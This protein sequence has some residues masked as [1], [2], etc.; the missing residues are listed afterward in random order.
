MSLHEQLYQWTA[1]QGLDAEA[2]RRLRALSGV[3]DP[4]EGL[5]PHLQRGAATLAAGLVGLGAMLWVAANWAELGRVPRFALLQG[6]LAASLLGAAFRPAWRGALGLLAV[7]ALGGLL[8]FFGQT[9]QT[10]ADA[11]QLFALWAGLALP[12]AWGARSELVWA[13]WTVVA[14]TAISLWMHT[15]GGGGWQVSTANLPVHALGFAALGSLCAALARWPWA[16]RL[17]VLL[18]VV[19]LSATALG[20]L[21][22]DKAIQ[23]QFPLGLAV[24]AAAFAVAWTRREVYAMSAL[25]LAL[26]TLIVAGA[27]RWVFD[28]REGDTLGHLLLLGLLAAG[29]VAASVSL[30]LKRAGLS[31]GGRE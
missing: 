11:W 19:A 7:L 24:L 22:F 12:L 31:L 8:A 2:A 15:Y 21:F 5:W 20:G 10:G 26:D 14:V 9:Y 18:G 6:L 30:V 1:R 27:A 25:A 13:P 3:D 17:A 23:P 16:W 4:P 28:I 29:V